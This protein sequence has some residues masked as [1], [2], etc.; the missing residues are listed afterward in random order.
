[1]NLNRLIV[2]YNVVFIFF[3]C[4]G[5]YGNF[6]SQKKTSHIRLL[7]ILHTT[8]ILNKII[9]LEIVIFQCILEN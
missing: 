7:Y 5:I 6:V 3:C 4:V 2:K 1:M 8:Y 9:N